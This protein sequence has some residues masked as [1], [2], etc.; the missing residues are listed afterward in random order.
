MSDRPPRA[1]RWRAQ[2]IYEKP[3]PAR[4]A[5]ARALGVSTD[6]AGLVISALIE[7]GYG[8]A[9]RQ[10]TNGMLVAYMEATTPPKGHESVVT[11]IGKARV[12]WQ[13]MLEQGTAM[14]MSVKRLPASA[15]EA[16]EDAKHE[17]AVANGETPNPTRGD[18]HGE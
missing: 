7:A 4:L 6:E 2:S 12:R 14:A 16:R 13:A 11:A 9:P 5:I 8:V 17:S 10:P 3:P 1:G 18:T 15:I